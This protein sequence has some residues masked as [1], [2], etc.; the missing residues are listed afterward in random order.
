MCASEFQIVKDA[1]ASHKEVDE[2]ALAAMAVLG[3][4]LERIKS[5][6]G[7]FGS[8]GFSTDVKKLLRHKSPATV[9]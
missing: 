8:V 2:Q 1:V 6:G 5:F 7:N 4:R 9:G 3:D